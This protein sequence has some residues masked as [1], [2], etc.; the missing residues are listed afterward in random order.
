M[1]ELPNDFKLDIQLEECRCC[2]RKLKDENYT[3]INSEIQRKFFELTQLQV[4]FSMKILSIIYLNCNLF[5]LIQSEDFSNNI[6]SFC[7][8]DLEV[9]SKFR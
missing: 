2:F 3:R 4:T 9:F 6:C 7:D 5:Q 1:A 8:N